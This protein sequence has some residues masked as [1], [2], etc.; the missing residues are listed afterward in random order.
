MQRVKKNKNTY[1]IQSRVVLTLALIILSRFGT[2]I[3]VPGVDHD[4]F[5]QSISNNPIVSFL[6]IF[7][8]GGFASIGVFALGIVPYINASILIQLGTT[9]IS[10]LEKLQKEEGEAGRQRISQITR[11]IALGWAVVQS[12]GVS[13]WVRPYVFNWDVQFVLEMTLALTTG[14]MLVMWIS[15]Q[16]TEKGV[17]NGA[18]MLIFVNIIS[19]LPN[20]QQNSSLLET[21]ILSELVVLAL[22]FLIMIIGIIFIQEGTRRIPVVS[23]RQ[24]GK[25]QLENKTSYLPL[26]LNQ[27][28]VMP[29]IFASAFL[30]L[31][32]YI[33]QITTSPLI[34]GIA[35][36]LSPSGGNKIVY[37][38]FYF[39][40][41]LFFS[42]FYASLIL[43]PSDVSKNLKKMES[44]IPGVR[45]GKATTDYLQKT[46]NRLTF[47]GALFLAFIAV[48]PSIIENLTN[49]STFKGL[50][51]TSLLILVGVA[52]DTSKQVQTYMISKNYESILK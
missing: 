49:I 51:A 45:P 35:N 38:I 7:S 30:V 42:Y 36:T 27:G 40:L 18:S 16:I 33:G 20:I 2:F 3:P 23:A 6:N 1:G 44:S 12:V 28:G 48:V 4:A 47:L 41:I 21:I 8:G 29:I 50:G 11:Y 37:L 46:L 19:G 52:I 31:P 15:E 17:G 5:Y 24:L 32:A 13:F 10:S 26:R 34:I 25:G 22:I 43:N 39:V 14:S 9:S